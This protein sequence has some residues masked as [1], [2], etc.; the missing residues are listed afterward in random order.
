MGTYLPH[1]DSYS[2]CCFCKIVIIIILIHHAEKSRA[3]CSGEQSGLF[4]GGR[5]LF[6]KSQTGL[7]GNQRGVPALQ[8]ECFLTAP[9]AWS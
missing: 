5:L 4:Q 7:N 6:V 3:F 2:R 9:L 8:A 1:F